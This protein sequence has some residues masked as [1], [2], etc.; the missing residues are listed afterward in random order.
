MWGI[1][2]AA[3]EGK[4]IQPLAFSKELLPVGFDQLVER[5]KPRAVS[6]FIVERLIVGGATKICFIISPSKGDIVRYHAHGTPHAL[7]VYVVQPEPVGLCDAVFRPAGLIAANEQ[8][9]IGLPDTVWFPTEGFRFLPDGQLSLLLFPVKSPKYFDAVVLDA[10]NRV[11]TIEVKQEIPT[12]HWIWGAI[13]MSGAIY[14]DLRQLWIQRQRQDEFL[15]TLINAW[16]AN[17]GRAFGFQKGFHYL[18]VGTIDGLHLAFSQLMEDKQGEP[19]A[20]E[21]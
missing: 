2:P 3:G 1:I 14:H 11:Q 12:T 7:F 19:S 8:V 4:R 5:K 15:G 10:D 6:E 16:I 21:Q 18:D 13:K 17:G 20:T 9:L